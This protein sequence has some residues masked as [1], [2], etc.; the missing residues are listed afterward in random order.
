MKRLYFWHM[1]RFHLFSNRIYLGDH[2]PAMS[3]WCTLQHVS[4]LKFFFRFVCFFFS[5]GATGRT[6]WYRR[7]ES[8]SFFW[9]VILLGVAPSQI[10]LHLPLLLG[11]GH[12]QGIY[13]RLMG[14]EKTNCGMKKCLPLFLVGRAYPGSNDCEHMGN[15]LV[16]VFLSWHKGDQWND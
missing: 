14:S 9:I 1:F 15:R 13:V 6:K 7:G 8:S 16:N 12:T 5:H 10:N 4:T 3:S 11:G 2:T